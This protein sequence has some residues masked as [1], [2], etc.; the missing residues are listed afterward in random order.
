M[1]FGA[2]RAVLLLNPLDGKIPIGLLSTTTQRAGRGLEAKT[3]YLCDG[4]CELVARLLDA[5]LYNAVM[6]VLGAGHGR[7]DPAFAFVGL[8]LALAEAVQA[9]PGGSPLRIVTIIVFQIDTKSLPQ[10]R[11]TVVKRALIGSPVS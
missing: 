5:H 1:S 2:G 11:Q 9:T 10:V 3:S 8:L 4:V 7:I 6:P